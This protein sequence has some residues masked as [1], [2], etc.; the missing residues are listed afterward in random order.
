[1]K[2]EEPGSQRVAGWY[3]IGFAALYAVAIIWHLR[4]AFEHFTE[5]SKQNAERKR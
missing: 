3:H 4:G 5:E 2:H 1:M